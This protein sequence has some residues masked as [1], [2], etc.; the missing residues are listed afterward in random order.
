[1]EVREILDTEINELSIV[2]KFRIDRDSDDVFR[3]YE[4]LKRDIENSG[5]EVF[6][7]EESYND[8]Q[9]DWDEDSEWD[10]D[11]DD[12]II[13]IDE[14]EL[15]AYMNEFFLIIGNLPEPEAY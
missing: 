6:Y 2:V 12:D 8:L 11:V 10:F 9:D 13:N 14:E 7:T 4:F 15:L 1:M 3:S 5:Y